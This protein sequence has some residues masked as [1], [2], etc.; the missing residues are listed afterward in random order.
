MKADD[1]DRQHTRHLVFAV[2]PALSAKVEG[3][4]REDHGQEDRSGQIALV[5]VDDPLQAIGDHPDIVH[6]RNRQSQD[7]AP[8]HGCKA[9]PDHCGEENADAAS[10]HGNHERRKGQPEIKANRN[11]GPEPQHRDKMRAPDR[12]TSR[13]RRQQVPRHRLA[14]LTGP[15]VPMQPRRDPAA[16]CAQ[17]AGQNHQANIVLNHDARD[18]FHHFVFAPQR[19]LIC[20]RSRR[21]VAKLGQENALH[22]K[23]HKMATYGQPVSEM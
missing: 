15:G 11:V 1:G 6:T 19:V 7:R 23:F 10:Q 14:V 9:H 2:L 22:M 20:R 17:N 13:Q 8:D 16:E 4:G 5:P 3:Q 21:N 12:D 18:Y